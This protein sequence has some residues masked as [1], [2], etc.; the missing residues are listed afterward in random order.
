MET[1]LRPRCGHQFG[2]TDSRCENGMDWIHPPAINCREGSSEVEVLP[3]TTGLV[4][5]RFQNANQQQADD[6]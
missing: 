1:K 4:F 5:E 3:A 2:F 6:Y